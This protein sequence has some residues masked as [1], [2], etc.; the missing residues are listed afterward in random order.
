[1]D[2]PIGDAIKVQDDIA[3]G[4]VRAIQV[5]VGAAD[6]VIRKTDIN[7]AAYD[8]YLRARA[9]R[10]RSDTQG[11]RESIRY[12]EQALKIAPT[13]AEAALALASDFTDYVASGEGATNSN[14]RSASKEITSRARAAIE[15]AFQQNPNAPSLYGMRS[16]IYTR[17]DLNFRAAEA[18]MDS[19][20]K[21][22]PD[23]SETQYYASDLECTLGRWEAGLEHKRAALERDPLNA[24]LHAS[25]AGCLL[26]A[27]HPEE[28]EEQARRALTISPTEEISRVYLG[29]AA[30]M[31][32]ELAVAL[33]AFNNVPSPFTDAKLAGLAAVYHAM[34]RTKE[35]DLAMQQLETNMAITDPYLI[36][37]AHANREEPEPALQWLNRAADAKDGWIPSFAKGE[38]AFTRYRSDPRY[39][40]WLR[41]LN[42]S[43]VASPHAIVGTISQPD[44]GRS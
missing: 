10:D 6:P 34:T 3:A 4:L 39:R 33:D 16:K 37:Q 19:G 18:E 26:R 31:R 28:A 41:K 2:R 12:Y 11:T 42:S 43:G 35:S 1:M 24:G 20:I 44:T 30:L 22:A 27:G 23:D 40:E 25:Y 5:A 17:Q 36:A 29:H 15:A 13:F 32:G 9:V 7:P 38:P 21:I 14:A 8:L